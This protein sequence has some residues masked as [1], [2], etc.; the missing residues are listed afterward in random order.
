[1]KYFKNTLKQLWINKQ[2]LTSSPMAL[3]WGE[4]LTLDNRG[5]NTWHTCARNVCMKHLHETPN[6]KCLHQTLPSNASIKRLH[7]MLTSNAYI[8]RFHQML[9]S[10]AYIKRLHQTPTLMIHLTKIYRHILLISQ[11]SFIDQVEHFYLVQ[12]VVGRPKSSSYRSDWWSKHDR[13]NPSSAPI[14]VAWGR[15]QPRATVDL[16][17]PGLCRTIEI[18]QD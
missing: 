6:R 10:N 18:N 3:K 5:R 12:L 8:K 11:T 1:M 7:Q 15:D 9:T 4:H 14:R 2:V 16:N 17:I 13:S